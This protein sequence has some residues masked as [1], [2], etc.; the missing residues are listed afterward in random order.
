DGK[1]FAAN[2]LNPPPRDFTSAASQKKLTRER[3]IRS[4]T[5]GRPGTAMMPWK[6]VLTPADIR[7]VVHYIRQ[8]LMHVRP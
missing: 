3:M 6:S 7:A 2:V 1:T 8:E 4:A 5:E